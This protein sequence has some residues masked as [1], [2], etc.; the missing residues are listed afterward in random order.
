MSEKRSYQVL[1]Q[2]VRDVFSN[3]ARA[4]GFVRMLEQAGVKIRDF[5]STLGHLPG[6][7][8]AFG[9]GQR[10]PTNYELYNGL[11]EA[12]KGSL[13]ELYQTC[14]GRLVQDFPDLRKDYFVVFDR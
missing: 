6:P 13:K 8:G 1:A 4:E 5:D 10:F 3:H 11:D 2:E 7:G 9:K 14:L 12:E